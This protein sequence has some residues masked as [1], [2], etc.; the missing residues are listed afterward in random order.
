MATNLTE[1][2]GCTLGLIWEKGPCTPYAV[3]KV[4]QASP[5]PHWSGSAG[6]IYPLVRRLEE[7]GLARSKE[8]YTGE[9]RRVLYNVTDE[10]LRALRSWLGPD[11]PPWSVA[12]PVDPLRTRIRFLGALNPSER[13]VFLENVQQELRTQISEAETKSDSIDKTDEPFRFLMPRGVAM[14]AKARLAWV[15]EA[16]D[17]ITT[18]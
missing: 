11:V 2:E 17:L 4:Y 12:I 7:K 1:L 9:R 6:A 13:V 15:E 8:A 10:G 5:N 3:R 18:R 14:I 16:M